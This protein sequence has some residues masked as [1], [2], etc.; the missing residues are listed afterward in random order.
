MP[1]LTLQG[2]DVSIDA[3]VNPGVPNTNFGDSANIDTGYVA[4]NFLRGLI[5]FDLSSIP[6]SAT[7][8]SATMS[9]WERLNT[10]PTPTYAARRITESWD[11]MAVT[12]NTRPAR[13]DTGKV[14]WVTVNNGWNNITLT[15]MV[16]AWV[17]GTNP[18]YGVYVDHDVESGTDRKIFHSSEYATDTSRRPK[19]VIEYTVSAR[20]IVVV[21]G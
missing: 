10:G 6:P 3:H 1:T 14:T 7:I 9:L 2:P 13:T 20:T 18:N 5:R 17:N 4:G 15:A 21:I 19:L 16:Q 12:W 8:V 11:E